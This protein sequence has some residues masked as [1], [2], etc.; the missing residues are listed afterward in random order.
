MSLKD[1]QIE[2]TIYITRPGILVNEDDFNKRLP[3][4][5]QNMENELQPLLQKSV[6]AAYNSEPVNSV[7]GIHSQIREELFHI[8]I[9]EGRPS[10]EKVIATC[11]E[12]SS[13]SACFV[14]CGH[15]AMVDDIRAAV[16]NNIDNKEGKRVDYYEQ[17]QVWA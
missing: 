15:P 5:G 13:G 1:T 9:I 8:K 10:I 17:L 12:D 7:G 4:M 14:T 2:T 6:P 11:I 3:R 16:A